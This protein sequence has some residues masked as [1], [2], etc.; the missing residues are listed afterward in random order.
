MNEVRA[1][2]GLTS[3]TT[4]LD[5]DSKSTARGPVGT[6]HFLSFEGYGKVTDIIW[7]WMNM[8]N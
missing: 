6:T 5:A 4:G 8:C 2:D 1:T 3:D 7:A